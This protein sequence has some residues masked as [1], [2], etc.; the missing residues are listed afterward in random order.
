MYIDKIFPFL[1]NSDLIRCVEQTVSINDIYIPIK[2]DD[3]VS[4]TTDTDSNKIFKAYRVMPCDILVINEDDSVAKRIKTGFYGSTV[5]LVVFEV[6]YMSVVDRI[7]V[8]TV[9]G[10]LSAT[11]KVNDAYEKEEIVSD[12]LINYASNGIKV[13]KTMLDEEDIEI[14]VKESESFRDW[15]DNFDIGNIHESDEFFNKLMDKKDKGES[16]SGKVV[17]TGKD[18]VYNWLDSY[19]ALPENV[20]MTNGGREVVPLLIGPTAVFKSAT[21]KELCRKYNFRLVDFRV[22]FTSRLDYS[23]L[24]QIGDMDDAKFSY[25]C[26][27]EEIV[28]CSDGFR[29]Y[30]RKAYDK[31]SEIL[32]KKIKHLTV[33]IQIQIMYHYLMNRGINLQIYSVSIKSI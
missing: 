17:G 31:V 21:V 27:M 18:A 29:E 26:P 4:V 3:N 6:D 13:D 7:S 8:D 12:V 2:V 15:M 5:K 20:D 19:F 33:R 22:S 32:Q 28:T 16:I 14:E 24:F 11:I 23:G 9:D 30:C 1:K 25:A 10:V